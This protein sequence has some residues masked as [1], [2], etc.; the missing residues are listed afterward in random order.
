MKFTNPC[1][2]A[3]IYLNLIASARA[4]IPQLINYQGRVAVGG[5]NFS[6]AGQFKFALVNR[7]GTASYWSNDG[8]SANASEP[9]A[10]TPL[11]V[12]NGLYSVLLGDASLANMTVITADVFTNVDVRLRVW[13]N[14][15][16]NGSQ[17][18]SPDQRIAAVGYALM[19]ANV[20]DGLVTTPKLADGAVTAA[21]LA[22]NAVTSA[23]VSTGAITSD[24]LADGAITTAKL[25]S[26][27]V[28]GVNIAAGS[29]GT[30]QLADGAVTTAKLANN[31]VTSVNLAAGAVGPAQ[32]S[33]GAA[34][35]NLQSSG[36]IGVASG[37]VILSQQANASSLISAGY[38]KVGRAQLG[39]EWEPGAS[40]MDVANA[41]TPR[42]IHTAVWTGSEMIVWGGLDVTFF[43][44]SDGA[45]YNPVANS[46]A[47]V[48]DAGAPSARYAQTAVWTGSEM[49][50][51]GGFDG[52]SALYTGGRYNP[53]TDAWTATNTNNPPTARFNYTAIWTGSAMI[54][55]GGTDG[56]NYLNSG[57]Q[58]SLN[59][60]TWTPTSATSAPSGR[61][62]HTAVWTGT[63]MLVWGGQDGSTTF[64][65]GGR[66][67]PATDSWVPIHLIGIA[68]GARYAHT[69]IWTGGT[70]IVWGGI[71]SPNALNTGAIFDPAADIWTTTP[72]SGAPTGRQ[73]HT[74]VWTGSEMIIWGGQDATGITGFNTGGRYDP[75]GDVWSSTTLTGAPAPRFNHTAIW[76]GVEML[77]FGGKGS[78]FPLDSLYKY[79]PPRFMYLYL[80]P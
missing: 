4:Q 54:V 28:T 36:Q 47:A 30:T 69:A 65:A 13:F 2:I 15:N 33:A 41:P 22:L 68:P 3:I 26:S 55:W 61:R 29:I 62:L 37:G 78:L 34:L 25:A 76:T 6:G 59:G 31:A 23:N 39:D 60:D 50:I 74:A 57:G 44:A 16:A 77:I 35:S 66:Y 12:V 51:W 71:N 8:T 1:L 49:I 72:T 42:Y 17:L 67:T 45:R 58:Y 21:K 79:A 10:A 75:A 38:L 19:A 63:E 48:T 14:D 52:V 40:G 56:S 24:G 64:N 80:K 46:W 70:M 7:D 73:Y 18:L 53:A 32:L 5:T 20:P 43:P 9:A 27:A 11:T